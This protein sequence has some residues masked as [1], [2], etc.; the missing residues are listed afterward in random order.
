MFG[1]RISKSEIIRTGPD[2]CPFRESRPILA[3]ALVRYTDP[4]IMSP[5]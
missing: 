4:V 5:A 1:S 3:L 2:S